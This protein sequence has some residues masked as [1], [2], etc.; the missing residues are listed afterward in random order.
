MSAQRS[1]CGGSFYPQRSSGA[2]ADSHHRPARRGPR[3]DLQNHRPP[4]P[5]HRRAD[6]VHS[7][8]IPALRRIRIVLVVFMG[9]VTSGPFSARC[10]RIVCRAPLVART[11][12]S[13]TA[14]QPQPHATTGRAVTP[15]SPVH[16]TAVTLASPVHQTAVTPGLTCLPDSSDPDLT[17][18][19]DSSDLSLTCPPD[20]SDPGLTCLPDSSDPSLTCLP[21]T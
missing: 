4:A 16:Q 1:Q 15:A 9:L 17:C 19:P 6:D 12:A 13:G 10:G 18:L 8:N 5:L 11:A 20:S 21:V 7:W 3:H 2:G 14:P